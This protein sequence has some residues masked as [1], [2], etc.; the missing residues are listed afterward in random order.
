MSSFLPHFLD[1]EPKRVE[2]ELFRWGEPSYRFQQ[3]IDQYPTY[4]LNSPDALS[5][6][7]KPLRGK[8][9]SYYR[10]SVFREYSYLT[11]RDG[12]TKVVVTLQDGKKVEF[13]LLPEEDR[14]TFCLS[15]QVG[16]AFSCRFCRT[17]EGGF[18]RNLTPSEIVGQYLLG[19]FLGRELY[20]RKGTGILF[21]GMGE[22]FHN[23]ENLK[24]ALAWIEEKFSFSYRR[25]TVS[26]VGV[27][28]PLKE[29]ILF[30]REHLAISLHSAIPSVRRFLVPSEK[31][32]P[33]E[34]M[35]DLL[36]RYKEHLLPP[37]KL[38]LE[39]VLLA[40][41]NDDEKNAVALVE[42][43]RD[44]P[45]RIQ[46]IPYNP[47]P[48]GKFTRPQERRVFRF[49]ERIRR[50]GIPVFVRKTKGL[51]I[52]AACGTLLPEGWERKVLSV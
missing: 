21:M 15:T 47:Y 4:F 45:V 51:G 31:A 44:L 18:Q 48:G 13:V 25:I 3:L 7:P 29:F 52:L 41:V 33:I 12:T 50:E 10:Y 5:N 24:I 32:F 39:V 27:L 28:N 35:K 36:I 11:D 8:F 46:L 16:C 30:R 19:N 37:R 49:Q 43:S 40:G 17:G 2:E 14:L 20:F 9:F 6:W 42:F 38:T 23:F 22:P 1:Q 26:T 34:K